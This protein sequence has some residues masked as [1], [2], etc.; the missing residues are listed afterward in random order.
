M[1]GHGSRTTPARQPPGT[2]RVEY[3]PD[4]EVP[5]RRCAARNRCPA[6][7]F[8]TT[9]EPFS[10]SHRTNRAATR[11]DLT[12]ASSSAYARS[13]FPSYEI[14]FSQHWAI[15]RRQ[16]PASSS[17]LNPNRRPAVA[18][19]SRK[20]IDWTAHVHRHV[21]ERCSAIPGISPQ[22]WANKRLHAWTAK[23]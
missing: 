6:W 10:Y 17:A 9:R 20:R 16:T 1:P 8:A 14:A 5:A 22:Y 19:Q 11:Q 4:G 21:S 23:G 13:V 12:L 7:G 2:A 15:C 18:S 3:R